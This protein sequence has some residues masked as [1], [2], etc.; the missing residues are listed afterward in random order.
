M[1]T[2]IEWNR[3]TKVEE[4]VFT[5][6]RDF[7]EKNSEE[8]LSI[9]QIRN[10]LHKKLGVTFGTEAIAVTLVLGTIIGILNCQG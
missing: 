9:G 4:P 6:D 3:P 7:A 8:K 5:Y 1:Y 10:L 2:L